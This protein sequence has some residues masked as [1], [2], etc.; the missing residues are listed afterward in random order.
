MT[1]DFAIAPRAGSVC[2]TVPDRCFMC[3]HEVMVWVNERRTVVC[4]ECVETL[5]N[6]DEH[7]K[8]AMQ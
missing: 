3:G 4:L 7:L 6:G 1:K 8:K 2:I 5:I